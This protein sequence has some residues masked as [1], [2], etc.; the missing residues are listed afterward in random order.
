LAAG[1]NQQYHHENLKN[2]KT[3]IKELFVEWNL[4]EK[5]NRRSV[6]IL[7]VICLSIGLLLTV[8]DVVLWLTDFYQ[9]KP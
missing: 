9:S 5:A 4:L 6:I 7:I 1:K 2:K 3:L 8:A